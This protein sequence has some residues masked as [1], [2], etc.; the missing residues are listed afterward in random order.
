MK[1]P[2]QIFGYILV[3]VSA[4]FMGIG[5]GSVIG[6]EFQYT[7]PKVIPVLLVYIIGVIA[8][9][10]GLFI[11]ANKIGT[12]IGLW[13]AIAIGLS[14]FIAVKELTK[15]GEKLVVTTEMVVWGVLLLVGVILVIV[16][17]DKFIAFFFKE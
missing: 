7:L 17:G 9:L 2:A 1:I 12:V 13:E 16:A 5:E 8:Y 10:S 11:L 4:I 3:I 14:I 6:L 15:K